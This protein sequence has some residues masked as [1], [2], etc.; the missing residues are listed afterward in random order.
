MPSRPVVQNQRRVEAL[1]KSQIL[2]DGQIRVYQQ[3][4]MTTAHRRQPVTDNFQRS[5]PDQRYAALG[6]AAGQRDRKIVR[7]LDGQSLQLL[8]CEGTTPETAAFDQSEMLTVAGTDMT[9]D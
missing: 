8:V 4:Q 5:A 2:V 6:H 7:K 3:R 1:P 9:I